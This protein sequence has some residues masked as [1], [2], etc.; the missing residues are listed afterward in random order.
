MSRKQWASP[1]ME[2]VC[3]GPQNGATSGLILYLPFFSSMETLK[4]SL[5][6]FHASHVA[7][8]VKNLP[9]NAE[10]VCSIPGLGRSP[11]GGHSTPLQDSC[12]VNPMDREAWWA[13]VRRVTESWTLLKWF[14]IYARLFTIGPNFSRLFSAIHICIA[15]ASVFPRICPELAFQSLPSHVN[16]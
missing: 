13:P 16:L 7:Q 9:C 6:L 1:H 2:G 12:L 14:S 5:I 10:D 8:S 4:V 11:G 3:G 15:Q